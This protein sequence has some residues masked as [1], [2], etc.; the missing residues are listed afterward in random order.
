MKTVKLIQRVNKALGFFKWLSIIAALLLIVV[1]TMNS[2]GNFSW[3]SSVEV[4]YTL[5]DSEVEMLK[6]GGAPLHKGTYK[7]N[8]K[9]LLGPFT[10]WGILK[11]IGNLLSILLVI[12]GI[13]TIQ[14]L[15][16]N[17]SKISP[18]IRENIFLIRRLAYI[19]IGFATLSW[20]REILENTIRMSLSYDKS[21]HLFE[22]PMDPSHLY[23]LVI[24]F[25]ILVLATV[26]QNGVELKEE[27]ELTI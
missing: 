3:A 11:L 1:W 27:S 16:T 25:V 23:V 9:V 24:G 20:S 13:I 26:F 22:V 6:D 2:N 4:P 21:R 10:K 19:V 12:F 8:T 7:I 5:G 17:S 15:L 14:K 18:F